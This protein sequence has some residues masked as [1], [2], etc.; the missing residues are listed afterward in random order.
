MTEKK[1]I[2]TIL[3]LGPGDSPLYDWLRKK[4][5]R[6]LYSTQPVT[7]DFIE[8]E[9]ISFLISYGYR[10]ILSREV[11]N[12]FDRRAVNLHASYL[13]WNRGAD[14]NFWSFMDDTPKGVTIHYLDEGLDT[15]DIIVQEKVE[16]RQEEDSFSK[17]YAR[18][19]TQIQDLFKQNWQKIKLGRCPKIQQPRGGSFHLVK[20]KTALFESLPKGWDSR[21]DEIQKIKTEWEKKCRD[22]SA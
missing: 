7:L 8:Q 1:H 10:H 5:N 6:V 20:D 15:G 11:V 13:P 22:Q 19:Q 14:P 12:Y 17:T 4:E 2:E 21:V 18:L 9:N 3:F 16:F